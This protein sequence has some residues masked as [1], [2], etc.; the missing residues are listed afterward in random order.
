K[1]VMDIMEEVGMNVVVVDMT[2]DKVG[3]ATDRAIAK[4]R[5]IPDA[6]VDKSSR[7]DR[8]IRILAKDT[9][10]LLAKLENIL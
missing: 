10:D 6:I 5:G 9:N 2:K 1:D 7:K 3:E 4:A 8:N